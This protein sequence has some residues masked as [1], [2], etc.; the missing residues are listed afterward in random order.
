VT[1]CYNVFLSERKNILK[2]LKKIEKN[3]NNDEKLRQLEQKLEDFTTSSQGSIV[4]DSNELPESNEIS[5][6]IDE[7]QKYEDSKSNLIISPSLIQKNVEST[8]KI[9]EDYKKFLTDL[10]PLYPIKYVFLMIF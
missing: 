1:G 10:R 6:N 9:N 4:F 2:L 7:E 8:M 5:K 3:E